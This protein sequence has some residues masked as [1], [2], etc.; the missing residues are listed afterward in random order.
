MYVGW[1][2]LMVPYDFHKVNPALFGLGIRFSIFNP[3]NLNWM[4]DLKISVLLQFPIILVWILYSSR[5]KCDFWFIL[6]YIFHLF[7][8]GL[9][10]SYGIKGVLF[11]C[12]HDEMW[13]VI[14]ISLV[15]KKL[16]YF[17]CM[18]YQG[19]TNIAVRSIPCLLQGLSA[20]AERFSLVAVADHR[21]G[22]VADNIVGWIAAIVDAI[23]AIVGAIAALCVDSQKIPL[24]RG[25]RT[26]FGI[27]ISKNEIYRCN[28][29]ENNKKRFWIRTLWGLIIP[30]LQTCIWILLVLVCFIQDTY[31]FLLLT[32]NVIYF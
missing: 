21:V 2:G 27:L 12:G 14:M 18:Q 5:W 26:I 16:W 31:D 22:W 13:I 6:D 23:A 3:N 28:K 15:K 25:N 20:V 1:F 32:M 4:E 29:S 19:S 11:I 30:I 17:I 9:W 7:H 24:N 8:K 10:Q